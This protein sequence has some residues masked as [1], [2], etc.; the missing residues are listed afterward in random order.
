[1]IAVARNRLTCHR[2]LLLAIAAVLCMPSAA[3]DQRG[4]DMLQLAKLD[5]L[6]SL[7]HPWLSNINPDWDRSVADAIRQL[8]EG[9]PLPQVLRALLATL[10]D[11]LTKLVEPPAADLGLPELAEGAV[12]PLDL[13]VFEQ[14]RVLGL[15]ELD[16]MNRDPQT[17]LRW[18]ELLDQTPSSQPLIIDLRQQQAPSWY[19]ARY[20]EQFFKSP[21]LVSSFSTQALATADIRQRFFLG[22]PRTDGRDSDIYRAGLRLLSGER[23]EGAGP[24]QRRAAFLLNAHS[25][26]PDLALA[27]QARGQG[28]LVRHGD[29]PAIS[30][31]IARRQQLADQLLLQWRVGE[32]QH[33]DGSSGLVWDQ[34]YPGEQPVEAIYQDLAQRLNQPVL[35]Q[36]S[37]ASTAGLKRLLD[38]S[39]AADLPPLEHRLLAGI[40]V[41]R[42]MHWFFIYRDRMRV[43]PDE[44][45]RAAIP[46]LAAAS[47]RAAY[48]LALMKMIA[49][50][51]DSH[52]R[53]SG[54]DTQDILGGVIPLPLELRIVERRPLVIAVPDELNKVVVGDEI[55][56]VDGQS[57]AQRRAQL[58][59]YISY[60]TSQALD[61]LLAR[62]AFSGAPGSR[63][64]LLLRR[65]DGSR[66]TLTLPRGYIRPQARHAAV[67]VLADTLA[68][69]DLTQLTPRT[70]K[71]AM[72]EVADTR[73]LI[74]DLR[75]YPQNTGGLLLS[76]LQRRG[77]P[78]AG[79][80]RTPTIAGGQTEPS[81]RAQ[82][83]A[84]PVPS[85]GNPY[86]QPVAVLIDER[87]ISQ[88]ETIA[89][90]LR[91]FAGATLIGSPSNG[92]NGNVTV[93]A[94]PGG[95]S[96]SFSGL[97]F[98]PDGQAHPQGV[99][100]QPDISVAPTV[101]GIRAGRDE[102]LEAA[103]AHLRAQ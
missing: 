35:S 9:Q 72:A 36:A 71:A 77:E 38:I 44:A 59:P 62:T 7:Q 17:D 101:A 99:G 50:M 95:L 4:E 6:I 56:Q 30:H 58:Q 57:Y 83:W 42:V 19:A 32:L 70:L 34:H 20:A 94:L 55:L 100:L 68:Y 46:E 81:Y 16:Q 31:D 78:P 65:A 67:T 14:V 43:Q 103:V 18:K 5:G 10:D 37:R 79:E 1:M 3:A 88:A 41:W 102:V 39:M 64:K 47:T 22:W 93:T 69:L 28:L 98:E 74:L 86:S 84:A 51:G 15:H 97:T 8:H 61:A 82:L 80:W 13:G 26:V 21:L 45:L 96:L 33:A 23:L 12:Y 40:R 60:S 52:V 29:A 87:S 24:D 73:G 90:N 92:T 49:T 54:S 76:L 85:A 75:G 2:W 25:P 48:V 53:L 66:K 63:A 91:Q 27:L 89:G 11:P